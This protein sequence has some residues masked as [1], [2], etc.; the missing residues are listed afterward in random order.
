ASDRGPVAEMRRAHLLGRRFG[1]LTLR[2]ALLARI[3]ALAL[4]RLT[5][6]GRVVRAHLLRHVHPYL[7]SHAGHTARKQEPVL[8]PRSHVPVAMARRRYDRPVSPSSD[9]APEIR[10]LQAAARHSAGL[11]VF[12]ATIRDRSPGKSYR[13]ETVLGGF[14]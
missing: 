10:V 12:P 8:R 13:P 3:E 4:L 11:R 2:R 5:Q 14:L 1:K 6:F 7:P 9:S